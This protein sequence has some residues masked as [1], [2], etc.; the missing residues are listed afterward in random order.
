MSDGGGE[1]SIRIGVLGCGRIARVRHI[2]EYAD[3]PSF[4]P[5]CIQT[6]YAFRDKLFRI[7]FKDINFIF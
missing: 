1:N 7:H 2:P 5:D 6:V 3:N 4:G